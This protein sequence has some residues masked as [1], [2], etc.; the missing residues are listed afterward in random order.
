MVNALTL[1]QLDVNTAKDFSMLS[2]VLMELPMTICVIYNAPKLIYS[3]NLL[4]HQ[5]KEIA[6]VI[7]DMFQFVVLTT[8]L[9]EMNV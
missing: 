9:T 7:K 8:R 5:L 1:N 2:V 3:A 6:N 4:A